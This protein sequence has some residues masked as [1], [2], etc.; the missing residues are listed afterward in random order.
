MCILF[1]PPTYHHTMYLF[2]YLL[3][4]TYLPTYHKILSN[5]LNMGKKFTKQIVHYLPITMTNQMVYYS[6]N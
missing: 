6:T 5:D 1:L 2:A 4:L 3:Y